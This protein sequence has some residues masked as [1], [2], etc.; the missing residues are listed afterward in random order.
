[1]VDNLNNEVWVAVRDYEG[2][3]EVSNIGRV[4]SLS[5]HITGGVADYI[6]PIRILKQQQKATGY[7]RVPLCKDG[8]TKLK[9]VHRLVMIS[10]VGINQELPEVNHK[11]GLK[12]DNRLENLE[13]SNRSLNQK[14]RYDVLGHT[15]TNSPFKK[16]KDH[17]LYGK[18]P[19]NSIG[20]ICDTLGVEFK[21]FAEA[22]RCLGIYKGSIYE[23]FSG[24]KH[25]VDGLTFRMR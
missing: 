14:H 1:M 20:I 15:V 3:Y 22:E 24:K 21:S 2:L 10:F 8:V 25:H 6:T 9:S 19:Y 23:Y 13:W 11:N 7:L 4:K 16:G 18:S 5:K 17:I 12:D